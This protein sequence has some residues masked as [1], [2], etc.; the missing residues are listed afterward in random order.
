MF[1]PKLFDV[2]KEMVSVTH[3]GGR[4]VIKNWILGDPTLHW[5]PK[6]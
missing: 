2:A 1:A 5:W 3:L 6:S 4:I